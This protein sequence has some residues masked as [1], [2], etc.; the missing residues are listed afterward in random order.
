MNPDS[1]EPRVRTKLVRLD[2]TL[3]DKL[4]EIVAV[5]GITSNEFLGP[6]VATEIENRHRA[7]LPA[8]NVLR[9]ARER[10]RKIR[11]EAPELSNTLGGEG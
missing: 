6:L 8:I 10:A 3:A 9:H 1:A 7:N 4:S 5:E 2:E 11:D